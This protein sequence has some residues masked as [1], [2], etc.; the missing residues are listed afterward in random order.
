MCFYK[1]RSLSRP[2]FIPGKHS[3]AST[4]LTPVGKSESAFRSWK[5]PSINTSTTEN[6]TASNR[7]PEGFPSTTTPKARACA[8]LHPGPASRGVH[9]P[10]VTEHAL[11]SCRPAP[12]YQRPLFLRNQAACSR[13][14]CSGF[15]RARIRTSLPQG[16]RT[17]SE[18]GPDPWSRVQL[19]AGD[20]SMPGERQPAAGEGE[21]GHGAAGSGRWPGLCRRPAPEV[22]SEYT[23]GPWLDGGWGGCAKCQC[24]HGIEYKVAPRFVFSTSEI[25]P[26]HSDA[27][28]WIL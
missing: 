8:P 15:R 3:K 20:A 22:G 9:L 14:R 6:L 28:F 26:A 25:G 19:W 13:Y 12:P 27:E 17:A 21:G 1:H 7:L 24:V 2:S 23:W 10:P 16:R 5:H 4:F 11:S 18:T